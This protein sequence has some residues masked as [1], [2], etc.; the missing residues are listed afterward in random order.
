MDFLHELGNFKQ[1]IFT[2]QNVILFYILQQQTH[3]YIVSANIL[4]NNLLS[5]G[6]VVRE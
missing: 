4:H 2:P 6:I 5:R 1:K 3:T